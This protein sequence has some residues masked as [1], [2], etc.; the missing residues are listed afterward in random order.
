M[1]EPCSGGGILV[2]VEPEALILI[3]DEL[4]A[5][6]LIVTWGV[7]GPLADDAS[8]VRE[9]WSETSGVDVEDIERLEPILFRNGILGP[10]GWVDVEALRYLRARVHAK[11]PKVPKDRVDG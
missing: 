11:M 4:D 9:V 8:E 7:V 3:E 2:P 1:Q 10:G 5:Q 6:K